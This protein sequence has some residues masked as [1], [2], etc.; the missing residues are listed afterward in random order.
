[1]ALGQLLGRVALDVLRLDPSCLV[2]EAG[3][4]VYLAGA[5]DRLARDGDLAV[6][7]VLPLKGR[8]PRR[9]W[10]PPARFTGPPASGSPSPRR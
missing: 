9:A 8:R 6:E 4:P 5:G 10:S 1:M 2:G 7:Q 3:V